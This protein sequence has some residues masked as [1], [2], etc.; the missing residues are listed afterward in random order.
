M[1]VLEMLLDEN[2]NDNI[3]LYDEDGEPMEFE[4][5]AMIPIEEDTYFILRPIGMEE[6]EDDLAFVFKLIESED[7]AGIDLVDNDEIADLVFE[8]YYALFEEDEE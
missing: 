7:G 2:C 6:L 3:T 5:I 4:Q 8:Q 1:D